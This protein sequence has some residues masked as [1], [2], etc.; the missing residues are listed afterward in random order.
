MA[1]SSQS[2]LNV[3]RPHHDRLEI[4]RHGLEHHVHALVRQQAPD[5]QA[6]NRRSRRLTRREARRIDAAVDDVRGRQRVVAEGVPRVLAD[7]Q[8]PVE[9][10]VGGDVA[11][12]VPSAAAEVGAEHALAAQSRGHRG[13]AGGDDVLLMA[14]HD[15][16]ARKRADEAP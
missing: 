7:V 15:L 5:E 14:V 2:C 11:R 12:D 13:D 1:S 6:V 10:P 4:L 3:T 9:E 16:G 8:V